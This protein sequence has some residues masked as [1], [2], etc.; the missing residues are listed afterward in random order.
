MEGI[1]SSW[2]VCRDELPL[3]VA[4]KSY[5][6]CLVFPLLH[7]NGYGSY[8][9]CR[10]FRG[11]NILLN[12]GNYRWLVHGFEVA[13]RETRENRISCRNI[14]YHFRILVSSEGK[15]P[16]G[17]KRY[18]IVIPWSW[19]EFWLIR[20]ESGEIKMERNT[21]DGRYVTETFRNRGDEIAKQ[22]VISSL[23]PGE[24]RMSRMVVIVTW[25]NRFR[26]SFVWWQ[27]M[28]I[29]VH[30]RTVGDNCILIT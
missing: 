2:F 19:V 13:K 14:L 17:D 10:N 26:N 22:K 8:D 12:W 18:V 20:E 16:P 1:W 11:G 27:H 15:W 21:T 24:S 7:R 23:Y 29:M 3:V 4:W 9:K 28:M 5:F 6:L 25:D 30:G